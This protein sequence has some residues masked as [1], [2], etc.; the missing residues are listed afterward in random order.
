M[1]VGVFSYEVLADMAVYGLLGAA[2]C[3]ATF[4]LVVFGF[5]DGDLGVDSNNSIGEGSLTVFQARSAT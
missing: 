2:L 1:K 5:N 4:S 3:L